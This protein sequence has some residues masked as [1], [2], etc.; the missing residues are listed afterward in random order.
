MHLGCQGFHAL[1]II[2]E[3]I[4][5]AEPRA[6]RL[7]SIIPTNKK[8]LSDRGRTEGARGDKIEHE[9]PEL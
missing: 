9:G 8:L 4:S 6:D 2:I 7:S 5:R 3:Y 1:A